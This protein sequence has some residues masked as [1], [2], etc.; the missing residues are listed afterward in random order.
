MNLVS[1]AHNDG[2]CGGFAEGGT[3][4]RGR[5]LGQ[6]VGGSQV[7]EGDEQWCVQLCAETCGTE[8]LTHEYVADHVVPIGG[9]LGKINY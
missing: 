8:H 6:Y 1:A 2:E 5:R 7:G 9:L 4:W 3:G